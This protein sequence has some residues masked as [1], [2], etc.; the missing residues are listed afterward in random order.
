MY[1]EEKM[2]CKNCKNFKCKK[3]IDNGE[4]YLKIYEKQKHIDEIVEA[5]RKKFN[6]AWLVKEQHFS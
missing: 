1:K 4:I 6:K 3:K 2:T 5:E